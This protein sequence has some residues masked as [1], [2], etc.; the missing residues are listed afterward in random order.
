LNPRRLRVTG[1]DKMLNTALLAARKFIAYLK[2]YLEGK[3][4]YEMWTI[5]QGYAS[6]YD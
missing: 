2:A 4:D 1:F 3:S 6:V 5:M